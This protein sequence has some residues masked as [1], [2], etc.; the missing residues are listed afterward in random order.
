MVA[1]IEQLAQE[2]GATVELHEFNGPRE[3][4]LELIFGPYQCMM[5]FCGEEARRLGA[6]MGHWH[7]SLSTDAKYPETFWRVGSLN[8]FHYS[9]ATT[10]EST[11][12][13]FL[14]KLRDGLAILKEC[15]GVFA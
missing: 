9:K 4:G 11:L 14:K 3:I 7:T 8:T 2:C 15:Q 6:F 10:I 12:P 1:R 5:H 13:G